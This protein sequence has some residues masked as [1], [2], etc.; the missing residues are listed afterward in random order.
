MSKE[1]LDPDTMAAFSERAL[2]QGEE[3]K[4]FLHLAECQICR[5]YVAVHSELRPSKHFVYARPLIMA[6]AITAVAIAAGL[7]IHSRPSYA[8]ARQQAV[9]L[10]PRFNEKLRLTSLEFGKRKARP[11]A[12]QIKLMTPMGERW[13][14]VKLAWKAMP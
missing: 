14:T 12:D 6:A 9:A 1:H 5:E 11:A 2:E 3:A 7:L 4:V 8:P 13:V 10:F